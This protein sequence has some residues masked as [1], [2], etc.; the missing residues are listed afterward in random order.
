[1][2]KLR[3]D[4]RT[5]II[6]CIVVSTIVLSVKSVFIQTATVLLEI[7]VAILLNSFSNNFTKLI[8]R[9]RHLILAVI[10]LQVLFRHGGE[11]YFSFYFIKITEV[12]LLYAYSSILRYAVIIVGS[13]LLAKISLD[14]FLMVFHYYRMPRE[15]SLTLTFGIQY[16]NTF[17]SQIQ[18]IRQVIRQ[19]KLLFGLSLINKIK[20]FKEIVLPMLIKSL[21]EVQYKAIA[22][23]LKGISLKVKHKCTLKFKNADYMFFG[24]ILIYLLMIVYLNLH[25]IR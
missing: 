17:S 4:P 25:S 3:F 24:M 9:F 12:G 10:V 11:V 6:F 20:L 2:N 21:S 5:I 19:R 18:Y 1:M 23:E 22:L 14:E 8:Y 7:F 16:L 13:I 15:L